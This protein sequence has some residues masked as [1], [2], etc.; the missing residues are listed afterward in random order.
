MI[1]KE[2]YKYKK[3]LS[4]KIYLNENQTIIFFAFFKIYGKKQFH[5]IR[6]V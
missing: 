3:F 2:D 5:E 1:E 4:L 6:I